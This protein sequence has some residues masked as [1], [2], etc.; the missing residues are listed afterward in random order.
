M[1]FL[2][3]FRCVDVVCC[4]AL[5]SKCRLSSKWLRFSAS[6]Q[7]EEKLMILKAD[8]GNLLNRRTEI[9]SKCRHEIDFMS[10]AF[11]DGRML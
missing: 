11:A 7:I 3:L 8:K 5:G 4:G 10:R 9:I 2:F 6:S 1:T